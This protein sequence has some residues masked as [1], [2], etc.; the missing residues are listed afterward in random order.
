MRNTT[1]FWKVAYCGCS[2]V[3]QCRGLSSNNSFHGASA[4]K[5]NLMRQTHF[6]TFRKIY[7]KRLAHLPM[8][9]QEVFKIKVPRTSQ[10][11]TN[12]YPLIIPQNK[13]EKFRSGDIPIIFISS[14]FSPEV[15][16]QIK[17]DAKALELFGAGVQSAGVA[18][19]FGLEQNIRK[20]VHQLWLSSP[21]QVLCVDSTL[22]A[23]DF[24]A[25]QML[26][27][28]VEQIREELV[29]GS[30]YSNDGHF[31]SESER[32]QRYYNSLWGSENEQISVAVDEQDS[33]IVQGM[34]N[35]HPS[36]IEL[37]Y[38]SYSEGS[39]YRRHVDVIKSEGARKRN[40]NRIV[41]FILYLGSDDDEDRD[42]D[43]NRDGGSL[44]V[45][46]KE[47]VECLKLQ[48]V[49]DSSI[50]GDEIDLDLN[51]GE[52]YIDISPSP[53]TF[54]LFDSSKVPHAV[55]ETRRSRRCVVGWLGS[56]N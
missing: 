3:I 45:Y 52:E 46:G 16:D 14:L 19:G 10:V 48:G 26:F 20:D 29:H 37:S 44:R 53:G 21:G 18:K 54:V 35:L 33:D 23:G 49:K 22:Y 8:H 34:D 55:R 43:P 41:S 36:H 1:A 7:I 11:K 39:F 31:L 50:S 24:S 4:I 27:D 13:L 30:K 47:N 28:T 38:L 5:S 42:W 25:R 32:M 6:N 51:I 9:E 15:I 40:S 56:P 2:L 17:N 12:E